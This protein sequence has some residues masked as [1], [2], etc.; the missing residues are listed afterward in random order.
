MSVALRAGRRTIEITHPE[1]LLFGPT[2]SK[3]D[4]ALYY[5]RVA[6]AMLP[7]VARRALNLERY[8]RGIDG[9]RIIQQHAEKLP[10]W[11]PRVE[12]PR[13]AGGTV[14][15]VRGGQ[16][17]SLLYLAN[18]EC[19]TFHRWLSRVDSLERPDVLV[20]D[21]DPSVTDPAPLRRAAK[22]I[23]ALLGELGLRPWVM[24]TGSRGY[25]VVVA[26]R[27]SGDFERSRAFAKDVA[28]LA[29]A[30][31]PKLLTTAAR[32]SERAGKILIDV[33]R[34]AYGQTAV[35][36]YSVR[37]RPGAPVATPLDWS[38][39]EDARTTATRWT[40]ASVPERLRSG[41]DP[42]RAFPRGAASLARAARRLE[43]AAEE[44]RAKEV[45]RA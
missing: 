44:T 13:R 27:R 31:E 43:Q 39:L 32:K 38:E 2:V 14:A 5:E 11:I 45:H 24:T 20:F 10:G 19:I 18:L 29:A 36:P 37:A 34:N 17:A 35:A 22:V 41:G 4:L 28:A 12:V 23:G 16:L 9:P 3:R 33:M 15:H 1:K 30:R 42:W 21:L 6:E 25:H 7:H 40:L 8:P 26:L